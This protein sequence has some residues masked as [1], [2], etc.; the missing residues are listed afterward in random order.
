MHCSRPLNYLCSLPTEERE[1]MK[2]IAVR[3][4]FPYSFALDGFFGSL[5]LNYYQAKP[6][7]NAFPSCRDVSFACD[8][9]SGVRIT[10]FVLLIFD[11]SDRANNIVYNV[12]KVC[13]LRAFL[14]E[15]VQCDSDDP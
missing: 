4:V 1:F 2:Q 8:F 12:N 7:Q 15:H 9:S 13:H 11:C 6:S 5:F 14:N 10:S 3:D